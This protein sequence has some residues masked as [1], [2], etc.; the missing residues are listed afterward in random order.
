MKDINK[1]MWRLYNTNMILKN[2]LQ[3]DRKFVKHVKKLRHFW[4][5]IKNIS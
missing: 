2:L 4:G 5:E 3:I 1:I